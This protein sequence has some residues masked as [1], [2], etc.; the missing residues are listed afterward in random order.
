[1]HNFYYNHENKNVASNFYMIYLITGEN[2][3]LIDSEKAMI[4]SGFDSFLLPYFLI[5]PA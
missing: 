3:P 1:M 2:R 5:D 4:I